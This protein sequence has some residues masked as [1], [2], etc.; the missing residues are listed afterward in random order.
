MATGAAKATNEELIE[1]LH[2]GLRRYCEYICMHGYRDGATKAL[3]E[4]DSL[5]MS[6]AVA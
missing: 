6:D 5:N 4:L 2:D 1:E 3:A